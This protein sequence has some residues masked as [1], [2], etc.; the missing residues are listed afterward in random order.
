[1][2]RHYFLATLLVIFSLVLGTSPARADEWVHTIQSTDAFTVVNGEPASITL[3]GVTWDIATTPGIGNPTIERD[4]YG[5]Q[6]LKFGQGSQNRFGSVTLSTDYFNNSLVSQVSVSCRFL[7]PTQN[8]LTIKQGGVVVG[9]ET[10]EIGSDK[11]EFVVDCDYRIGGRLDLEF[12]VLQAMLIHSIKITYTEGGTSHTAVLTGITLGGEYPT[13]FTQGDA[14]SYEG[15]TVTAKYDDESTKDVTASAVFSGY[16]MQTIG[17]QT[18]TVSYTE[19]DVTETAAYDIVVN[20]LPDYTIAYYVD[21]VQ[22]KTEL[23]K[24]GAT[25]TFPEVTV[26]DWANKVFV[27]WTTS[28]TVALDTKPT[29][30]KTATATASADASYYAV[31]A[32]Q[33]NTPAYVLVSEQLD[34]W[35]GQYLIVNGNNASDAKIGT[36]NRLGV[37]SLGNTNRLA[38]DVIKANFGDKHNMQFVSCT[39]GYVMKLH[40]GSCYYITT[41][42]SPSSSQNETTAAKYPMTLDF[43][44]KDDVRIVCS[45]RYLRY[46]NQT[47]PFTFISDLSTTFPISL[48]RRQD[49]YNTNYT[50]ALTARF[51]IAAAC[52]DGRKY[53]TTYS[54]DQAFVVPAGITIEEISVNTDNRIHK[55]AFTEGC[56]VPAKT[57]VL[58]SAT[59]AGEFTA[60]FTDETGSHVLNDTRLRPTGDAGITAEAMAEADA[61]CEYFRLT[62]HNGTEPGFWWGAEDG[63]AFNLAPNKAYI[64]VPKTVVAAVRGFSVAEIEDV[65]AITTVE[66]PFAVSKIY[67]LSGRHHHDYG[68]RGVYIVGGKKVVR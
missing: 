13:T 66:N 25:L 35:T 5:G 68:R 41:G 8:V 46:T 4:S 2:N 27:G 14:F 19:A 10:K 3:N 47:S 54:S 17:S 62:M 37:V 51:N 7:S 6:N 57:G 22:V 60:K 40:D 30:V 1:M 55:A 42:G 48:Y 28:P 53:Y 26:P 32:T 56:V 61:D 36:A 58:I 15:M 34:D 44:T 29:L 67:D 9:S 49:S 65:T 31:Y 63:V 18:V 38:K 24:A 23:L 20:D 12:T 52:T 50:T 16:D 45:S 33:R 11:G 64:A 21:G 39:G 43:V 59:S